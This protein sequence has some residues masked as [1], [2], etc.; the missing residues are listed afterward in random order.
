LLAVIAQEVT[1]ARVKQF[2]G[3]NV[4]GPVTRYDVP[5]LNAFNF[6]CENALGGGGMASLRNDPLGKAMA[7]I[8]LSMP[9]R[10]PRALLVSV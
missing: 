1:A 4:A 5:G 9:V 10:V 2:L 6:V 7:Q 3:F 8:L